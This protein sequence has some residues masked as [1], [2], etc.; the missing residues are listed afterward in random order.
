MKK[1]KI[2]YDH[3]NGDI[4]IYELV[5]F[6]DDYFVCI[7]DVIEDIT[8]NMPNYQHIFFNQHLSSLNLLY[9]AYCND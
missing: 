7:E 6:T 5:N 3:E 4:W 2:Q 9:K 8:L 1:F